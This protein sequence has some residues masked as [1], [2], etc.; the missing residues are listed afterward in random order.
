MTVIACK[1]GDD[2][3][4]LAADTQVTKGDCAMPGLK[5]SKVKRIG[6]LLIAGSGRCDEVGLF[7]SYIKNNVFP[8]DTDNIPEY[9]AAFYRYRDSFS[10]W[11][12]PAPDERAESGN[13]YVVI[14]RGRV[15]VI[16]GLATFELND[17]AIY[18]TGS[19]EEFAMGVMGF[20]G[21]VVDAVRIACKYDINCSEPIDYFEIDRIKEG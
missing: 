8:L 7:N 17:G 14:G 1:V 2:K 10:E 20:G 16:G 3:I 9:M 21:T 5:Y 11:I 15:F 12:K 6:E 18:A 13:H 4:F 19:G